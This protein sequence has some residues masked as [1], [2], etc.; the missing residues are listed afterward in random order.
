M[1]G[2]RESIPAS[3]STKAHPDRAALFYS[4]SPSGH[5]QAAHALGGCL[6]SLSPGC[7]VSTVNLS[8]D[9]YPFL[10]PLVAKTYFELIQK[11]PG[12]WSY[13][14][15]NEKVAEATRELREMI[16]SLDIPKLKNHLERIDPQLI[17]ATHALSCSLLASQKAKGAL[18]APLIA[19]LT[20]FYPHCYW[21][22]EEVDLYLAPS[23]EA[24]EYLLRKGVAP[25]KVEVT[26]IPIDRA[27]E[28]P[29][30]AREARASLGLS[31]ERFTVLIMGGSKGIGPLEETLKALLAQK[32]QGLQ[33][34][35][36]CGSNRAL[37][38]RL[39]KRRK[40]AQ[41]RILG[42]TGEMPKIMAAS[43]LMAGKPGGVTCAEALAAGLPLVILQTLPGQEERNENY[44][45]AHRAALK[46]G[47]SRDAAEKIIFLQKNPR[48]L[49]ELR[50]NCLNLAHP[51]SSRTACRKILNL[52]SPA[53]EPYGEA[54]LPTDS[55]SGIPSR[56][57]RSEV[58]P[59]HAVGMRPAAEIC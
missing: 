8:E 22:E 48:R 30:S 24:K 43:D 2:L 20:D 37:K 39:E 38:L 16:R 26:G 1:P 28:N 42:H 59:P 19:V 49:Q 46:A 53:T 5:A 45:L 29:P 12:I 15:D 14:Y 10:G 36:V 11:S 50:N 7:R 58:P 34:L 21:I 54:A 6:K 25:E 56:M 4:H 55:G 52:F 33:I 9:L 17:I 32:D 40:P 3:Q 44:L 18:N 47:D 57:A 41:V 51:A 13:L 31:P 23:L 35:V 27:F